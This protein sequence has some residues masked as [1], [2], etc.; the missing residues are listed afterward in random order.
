MKLG[1]IT[2][3]HEHVEHL[4]TALDSFR[5]ANVERIVMIGDVVE[6][7]TRLE[8]TCR[9]LTDADAGGVQRRS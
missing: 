6:M 3:I 4:Q 1:L 7:T 9:L 8:E 2:D 5:S